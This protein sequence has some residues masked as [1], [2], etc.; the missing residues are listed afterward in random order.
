MSGPTARSGQ[1]ES[2]LIPLCPFCRSG[3]DQSTVDTVRVETLAILKPAKRV[4]GF[5]ANRGYSTLRH[6]VANPVIVPTLDHAGGG[7]FDVVAEDSVH[8]STFRLWERYTGKQGA[9]QNKIRRN[10]PIPELNER[11]SRESEYR[12]LLVRGNARYAGVTVSGITHDRTQG[13]NVSPLPPQR[14]MQNRLE[15]G[16]NSLCFTEFRVIP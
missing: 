13:Q 7:S 3:S 8:L 6:N 15:N 12:M 16:K 1:V 14:V 4:H 10:S 5:D 2:A 9:C 11:D